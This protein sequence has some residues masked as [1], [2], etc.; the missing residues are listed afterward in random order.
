MN[1]IDRVLN[2][3]ELGTTS[4]V[5][6]SGAGGGNCVEVLKMG[7][8]RVALRQSTDP[9]GPALIY[10]GAEIAAFFKRVKSGDADFLLPTA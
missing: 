6:L 2:S 5:K 4:W 3:E 1:P 9:K 8:G 10:T 7:D